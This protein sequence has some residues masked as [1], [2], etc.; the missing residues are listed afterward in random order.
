MPTRPTGYTTVGTDPSIATPR[1]LGSNP[2]FGVTG[3]PLE[4]TPLTDQWLSDINSQLKR[5]QW[6]TWFGNGTH[7]T[8][9]L[10]DVSAEVGPG[11]F[12]LNCFACF[13]YNLIP[14][15]RFGG[16]TRVRPLF[17]ATIDVTVTVLG[18]AIYNSKGT[19]YIRFSDEGTDNQTPP[20]VDFDFPEFGVLWVSPPCSVTM[21]P[22]ADHQAV[23]DGYHHLPYLA[24][25]ESIVSVTPRLTMLGNQD[26]DTR[27]VAPPPTILESNFGMI[28]M[29]QSINSQSVNGSNIAN[30][31]AGRITST[32]DR[33]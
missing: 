20:F 17:V 24:N 12:T 21:Q 30:F 2:A 18:A 19:F 14:D 22:G 11:F 29:D 3:T 25:D 4:S 23:L 13:N 8:Y 33:F 26:R 6:D 15:L 31:T 27:V 28:V 9:V 10:P 32:P 7:R 1:Q 5:D 16:D